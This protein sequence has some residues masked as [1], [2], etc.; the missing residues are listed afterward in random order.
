MERMDEVVEPGSDRSFWVGFA[1]GW[2]AYFSMTLSYALIVEQE[3]L[4]TGLVV[5]GGNTL[6]PVAAS[7][8]I[9]RLGR[10]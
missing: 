6:A 8:L 2:G 10:R 5:A 9:A 3:P 7:W 4:A 1:I